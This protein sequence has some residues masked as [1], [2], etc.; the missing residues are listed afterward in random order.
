MSLPVMHIYNQTSVY[1]FAEGVLSDGKARLA[2]TPTDN[3]LN[4]ASKL[5]KGSNSS[6]SKNSA[7]NLA[8]INA[9]IAPTA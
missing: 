5:C 9:K 8:A 1:S 4:T 6:I 2:T 3:I 7:P